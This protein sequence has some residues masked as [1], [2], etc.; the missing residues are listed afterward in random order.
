[1]G[2]TYLKHY[3]IKGM[4]WGVQNGPPYPLTN[5][6][7]S[8]LRKR[9]VDPDYKRAHAGTNVK[10]LSTKDLTVINNRLNQERMYE[11]YLRNQRLGVRIINL[12]KQGSQKERQRA[13]NLFKNSIRF[14]NTPQVQASLRASGQEVVADILK[15]FSVFAPKKK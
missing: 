13:N 3:G 5:A 4:R 1:M 10:Y 8:V 6:V 11:D 7:K 12:W 2:E 9:E 14:G 15:A